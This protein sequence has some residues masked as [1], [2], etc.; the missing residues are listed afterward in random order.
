MTGDHTA[1]AA[2]DRA[3]RLARWDR[4]AD[5]LPWFEIAAI[6]LK[7]AHMRAL[8]LAGLAKAALAVG[9]IGSAEAAANNALAV[10]GPCAGLHNLQAQIALRKGD[11]ARARAQALA[12]LA[13][14]PND[15]R[16]LS[17]LTHCAD[18]EMRTR[19]A[20]PALTTVGDLPCPDGFASLE[21]FNTA[22]IEALIT[23]TDLDHNPAGGPQVGGARLHD[24]TGL[25][26]RLEQ[27]V[28]RA[29]LA[30]AQERCRWLG[31]RWPGEPTLIGWANLFDA[32]AIERLHIH[33]RG[34]LSGVYY[35]A[36]PPVVEGGELLIGGHDFGTAWPQGLVRRI[37]P[38][39]GRIV[40][41]PSYLYHRV[42]PFS[43][44]GQRISI[45][46]DLVAAP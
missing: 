23:H 21:V 33:E 36:M 45:A 2:L 34:W 19:L 35:V 40:L 18:T 22:L 16:S 8:A 1:R 27:G 11:G 24:I 29:F 32:G 7:D 38:V 43:G 41:F 13:L 26:E 37:R 15:C 46:F 4:A 44:V 10:G 17:L 30:A 31:I 28:R 39:P 5:A 6:G 42:T 25:P 20:D 12:A 9:E 14:A 3:A